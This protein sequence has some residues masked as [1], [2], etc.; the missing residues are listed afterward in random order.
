M[1]SGRSIF[2]EGKKRD[3]W[4]LAAILLNF[5]SSHGRDE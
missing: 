2:D 5:F 1:F 4:L 3:D